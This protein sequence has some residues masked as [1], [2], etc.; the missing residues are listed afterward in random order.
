VKVDRWRRLEDLFHAALER[1]PDARATF[2]EAHCGDD[3]ELRAEIEALLAADVGSTSFLETPSLA[4]AAAL[5]LPE[6]EMAHIGMQIGSWT[7][8]AKIASGGMGVVYRAERSDGAFTQTVAIKMIHAGAGSAQLLERFQRE[9]ETLSRLEH[10]NIT[11]LYDGGATAGGIPYLV[12]EYVDGLA[13]DAHCDREALGIEARLELFAQVCAA[14][15]YAHQRLIVHRDLKPANVLVDATGV[16]KLCDFGIAKV[17]EPERDLLRNGLTQS[18]LQPMT[19]AYASPEQVR[20]EPVTTAS[21]VYSLGVLL[22]ELLCGERPYRTSTTLAHEVE[23]AICTQDPEKPSTATARNARAAERRSITPERL[24]RR[25]RGDL[26]NIVLMALRKEPERRYG[27]AAELALD[28]DRHRRGLPVS[29]R[30]DTWGYRTSKFLARHKAAAVATL[31]ITGVLVT[32]GIVIAH[33]AR[34]AE[35][36]LAKILRLSDLSR[37]SDLTEQADEL[38]PALPGNGAALTDWVSNARVLADHLESH[39]A[40]L[41]EMRLHAE[42]ATGQEKASVV[43]AADGDEGKPRFATVEEQWQHDKLAELVQKLT[44]FGAPET[45]LIDRLAARLEFARTVEQRTIGDH[46]EE[47]R[48]VIAAIGDARSAPIYDGL[49]LRPQIGLVPIGRDPDSGLYEFAHLQT[50][51]VPVRG[52]DGKLAFHADTGLVFVLLPG[53]TFSMGARKPAEGES[54]DLPNVD[55][56]ARPDEQPVQEVTLAPY[57]LSKYEMTQGQW[58]R[59]TGANPSVYRPGQVHGEHSIDLTHPVEQ[60]SW[61]ECE[62]ELTRLGLALPTEAQ[63]EYGARAGTTTPWWSGRDR[64]ALAGA[65]NLCDQAAARAGM[66]CPAYKTW[67][68]LDDGH[69]VHAPVG[70]FRANPFGTHDMNGNVWEWCLDVYANY[71]HP[72]R[73]GDGARIATDDGRRVGRGG[74]FTLGAESARSSHRGPGDRTTRDNTIGV[75]PAR[76]IDA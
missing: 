37:L 71:T 6:P 70:S 4:G 69:V 2:L 41:L 68:E 17:L 19:L 46:A 39:R 56:N 73:A 31:L 24:C 54:L 30:A 62:R 36:R 66:P 57:F 45:G 8:T 3:P 21:D 58:S 15:Q 59:F 76:T 60:I 5:P 10:P 20:G 35:Q 61:D 72:P 13:L 67:P 49:V 9:R 44:E 25:L 42:P 38:W 22:Y 63:W 26:D 48:E 32:A 47:W 65:V 29:A 14:V 53:G 7:T 64:S 33:S 52:E 28:L 18:G 27:S 51:T 74:G 40:A 11:R 1:E 55:P 12:M 34:I 16:P 43:L 75:R 23:A 50:G